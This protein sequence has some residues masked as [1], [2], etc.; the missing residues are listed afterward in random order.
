MAILTAGARERSLALRNWPVHLR[1]ARSK[2]EH[3]WRKA[4]GPT[5]ALGPTR[6]IINT[7]LD[8]DWKSEGP[9]DWDSDQ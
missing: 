8:I 7:L 1:R 5:R 4:T 9:W 6:A 2:P 3:R